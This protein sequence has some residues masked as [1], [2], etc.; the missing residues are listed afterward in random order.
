MGLPIQVIKYNQCRS[1]RISQSDYSIHIKLNYYV[2]KIYS[3]F[4]HIFRKENNTIK[5]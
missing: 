5:I 2:I 4:I 1:R 3:K